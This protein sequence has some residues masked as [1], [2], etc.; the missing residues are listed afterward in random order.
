M[1]LPQ[2]NK[3]SFRYY[4]IT[5]GGGPKKDNSGRKKWFL[6]TATSFIFVKVNEH[7]GRIYM[8]CPTFEIFCVLESNYTFDTTLSIDTFIFKITV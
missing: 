2:I 1:F 5:L 3:G 4:I 7:L 6:I 8:S